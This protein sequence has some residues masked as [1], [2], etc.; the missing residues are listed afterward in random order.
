MT[1]AEWLAHSY[2]KEMLRYLNGRPSKRKLR[3]FASACCRRIWHLLTDHRSRAVVE[4]VERYADGLASREELEATAAANRAVARERNAAL[5]RSALLQGLTPSYVV[6][7]DP[8]ARAEEA[9][10]E[11][12]ADGLE[13]KPWAAG[14]AVRQALAGSELGGL[15]DE[16]ER[17]YQCALIRDIFGNPFRPVAI[18]P[19]L[20]TPAVVNLAQ[21]AYDERA[22]PEGTLDSARLAALADAL[23][24]ASCHDPEILGHCRREGLHVRGC[25]A[26][27]LLLGK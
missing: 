14:R 4:V 1:E 26:V 8:E 10:A 25:W 11:A 27:D 20:R 16:A 3:L 9:V 2:P 18:D 6:R 23:E 19:P 15:V 5:L 12:G 13:I 21:A 17:K 7:D 24:G 22:L